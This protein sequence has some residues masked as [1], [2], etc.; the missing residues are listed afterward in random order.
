MKLKSK[1][2]ITIK[3]IEKLEQ[4]EYCDKSVDGDTLNGAIDMLK[5]V[6][7]INKKGETE[8]VQE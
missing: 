4:Y 6:L 3:L 1:D 2:E 8:D 7:G 5:W